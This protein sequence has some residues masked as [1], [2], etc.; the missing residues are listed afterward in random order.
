LRF[1]FDGMIAKSLGFMYVG[2]GEM[3]VRR[4]F[5]AV[6][7]RPGDPLGGGR[8]TATRPALI[9]GQATAGMILAGEWSRFFAAPSNGRREPDRRRKI[10]CEHPCH[11][12]ASKGS[13][14][15]EPPSHGRPSG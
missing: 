14:Q 11:G 3:C 8:T 10:R 1:W 7:P 12:A 6:D 13:T 5:D 2:L 9:G 4:D 15:V